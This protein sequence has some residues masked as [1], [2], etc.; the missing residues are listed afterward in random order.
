[1]RNFIKLNLYQRFG[2]RTSN[3]RT[4]KTK[5]YRKISKGV[6]QYPSGNYKVTKVV[7]GYRQTF[8]RTTQTAAKNLYKTL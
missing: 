8:W 2:M 4:N 1:M 6:Y 3:R 5:G 7:N